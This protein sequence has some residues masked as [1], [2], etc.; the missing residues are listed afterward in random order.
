MG[1]TACGGYEFDTEAD[2][3]RGTGFM[4]ESPFDFKEDTRTQWA[5]DLGAFSD[6]SKNSTQTG[7]SVCQNVGIHPRMVETNRTLAQGVPRGQASSQARQ[8][9]T[10][11]SANGAPL[12]PVV[13]SLPSLS[14]RI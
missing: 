6:Y 12:S 7:V 10:G 9:L 14:F 5:V 1:I 2:W 8:N 13:V 3:S 4:V 11:A